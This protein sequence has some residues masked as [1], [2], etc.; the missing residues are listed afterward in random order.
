MF[1]NELNN[2]DDSMIRLSLQLKLQLYYTLYRVCV[3]AILPLSINT[4]E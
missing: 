3:R 1:Y 4:W 2:L